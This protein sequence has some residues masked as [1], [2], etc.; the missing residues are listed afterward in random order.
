MFLLESGSQMQR[1]IGLTASNKQSPLRMHLDYQV[2]LPDNWVVAERHKLIPS[3]YAASLNSLVSELLLV[4]VGPLTSLF[5]VGNMIRPLPPVMHLTFRPC[6]N[7]T[8]SESLRRHQ[9]VT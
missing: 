5:V 1:A 8:N 6:L 4:I 9:P 2:R 3:G 7:W